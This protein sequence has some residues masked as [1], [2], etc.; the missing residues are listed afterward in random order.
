M[1]EVFI[2][3]ENLVRRIFQIFNT[4]EKIS[5][6]HFKKNVG[7]LD[8]VILKVGIQSW[9]LVIRLA[10][11]PILTKRIEGLTDE[12]LFVGSK[13]VWELLPPKERLVFVQDFLTSSDLSASNKDLIEL[14]RKDL[15][16]N[17]VNFDKESYWNS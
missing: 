1:G 10:D 17:G 9:R 7:G 13:I 3:E 11:G 6:Q 15:F 14:S 2:S 16:S 4:W 12:V 8:C 5:G